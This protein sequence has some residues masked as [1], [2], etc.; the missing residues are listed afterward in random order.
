[1]G[2]SVGLVVGSFTSGAIDSLFESGADSLSDLGDAVSDGLS[3]IGD[4]LGSVG[5]G[6]GEVFDA[7]F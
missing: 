5:E 2:A 7:I 3:E 4:T 1:M 6:A